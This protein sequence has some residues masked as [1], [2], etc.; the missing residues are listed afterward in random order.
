MKSLCIILALLVSPTV[1]ALECHLDTSNGLTSEIEDI[2][3]LLLPENQPVGTRLWTSVGKSRKVV[4][5]GDGSNG[6]WVYFYGNPDGAV[7]KSGVGMGIIYNGI[8]LGLVQKGSKIVTDIYAPPGGKEVSGVVNYQIYL[9]KIAGIGTGGDNQV[10]IFQLDGVGGI[11]GNPGKNYRYT[12]TGLS[13][14]NVTQCSVEVNVPDEINFGMVS[15]LE[16]GER[17]SQKDFT[18]QAVK[19]NSCTPDDN[20]MVSLV[21][22]PVDS[23]IVTNN[24][25]IDMGNNSVFSLRDENGG[26]QFD[27]PYI[28]WSDV[29]TGAMFSKTFSG[30]II[31]TG[32]VVAGEVSKSIVIHVNYS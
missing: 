19:N 26:L 12:L 25:G 29:S 30:E 10:A 21:F 15:W 28:F 23:M 16:A 22:S 24:T 31:S 32:P 9:E 13:N 20:M 17:V 27:T 3:S 7:M 5:W 8:D 18:I 6:E 1:L 11:N 4:C 2:G 14:I